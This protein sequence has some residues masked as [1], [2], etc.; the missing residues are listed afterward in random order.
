M[1]RRREAGLFGGVAAIGMLLY[2]L[3]S[4]RDV[5]FG[6]DCG[7]LGAA[8]VTLGIAHPTG[9]PLYLLLAKLATLLL[10]FGSAAQRLC[11]FSAVCGGLAVGLVGYTAARLA[12]SRAAGLLAAMSLLCA[13]RFWAQCLLIEVYAL[14]LALLAGL[15]LTQVEWHLTRDRRWLN[16]TGVL[17]GLALCNHVSTVWFIPG[18]LALLWLAREPERPPWAALGR[19]AAW[20][21]PLLLLYLYLPLR[22]AARPPLCWAPTD[23]WSG[24]FNHLTGRAY[25]Q[26]LGV[27]LPEALRFTRNHLLFLALDL[28][29]SAALAVVG[30]VE[31]ARRR[32]PWAVVLGLNAVLALGFAVA[33]RVGD[34]SNYVLPVDLVAAL[35]AGYGAVTLRQSVVGHRGADAL[36][37][38]TMLTG[39]FL[40]LPLLPAPP[41]GAAA[42]RYGFDHSTMAGNRRARQLADAVLAAAAPDST[43]LTA[44][45]ELCFTLWYRQLVEGARPD[46]KV[47]ALGTVDTPAGQARYQRVLAAESSQ[48]VVQLAFW[49]P[50]LGSAG[51][52]ELHGVLARVVPAG[53][54]PTI[55][56][57]AASVTSGREL[58]GTPAWVLQ[59]AT[60]ASPVS[61][62]VRTPDGLLAR[63][64]LK[65]RTL[66]TLTVELA[67]TAAPAAPRVALVALVHRSL[68]VDDST[69]LLN[70]S[71]GTVRRWWVRSTPFWPTS[72]AFDLAAGRTW[73][74]TLPLEVPARAQPGSYEVRVGLVSDA[75]LQGLS[76]VSEVLAQTLSVGQVETF[77]Q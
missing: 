74:L 29:W 38:R 55:Q 35:L 42:A 75:A 58:P 56:I 71:S 48:R 11:L 43:V 20:G 64:A 34:R 47:V 18:T 73:R 13:S 14:H 50:A 57:G 2:V 60:L 26:L 16:L 61:V 69:R 24:F 4:A 30:W 32:S 46:L 15:L 7:E 67:R 8:A 36:A 51:R 25:G 12:Q 65:P 52:L 17:Y 37:A 49:D 68:L 9:Y 3:T 6:G 33:Y 31:L 41:E 1:L 21:C 63:P 72:E 59:Q 5:T 23:T 39:L 77:E 62:P 44:C 66:A 70:D 54:I 10:P 45:D 27:S 40:L 53:E 22:A 28:R 76:G 19:V